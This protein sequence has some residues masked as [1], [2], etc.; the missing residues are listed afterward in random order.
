MLYLLNSPMRT[1]SCFGHVYQARAP[2]PIVKGWTKGQGK[3]VA[4]MTMFRRPTEKSMAEGKWKHPGYVGSHFLE[5]ALVDFVQELAKR[6]PEL[7]F[8]YQMV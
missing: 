2:I 4:A 1:Y 6:H 7:V 3:G 5:K 8:N